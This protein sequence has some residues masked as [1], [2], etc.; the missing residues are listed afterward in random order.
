M[1]LYTP[2]V[3]HPLP[4]EI[5]V[6]MLAW[7]PRENLIEHRDCNIE[8]KGP[9]D[10]LIQHYTEAKCCLIYS[11]YKFWPKASRVGNS[12]G[13]VSEEEEEKGPAHP[14]AQST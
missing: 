11:V 2:S 12:E 5:N 8:I 3:E 13:W 7:G 14:A 10:A 9:G 4:P 1:V 6:D